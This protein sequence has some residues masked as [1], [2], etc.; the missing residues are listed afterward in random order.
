MLPDIIDKPIFLLFREVT[1][2][3]RAYAHTLFFSFVLISTGLVLL[4]F[5][6]PALLAMGLS[7]FIHITLDR[8]WA[9]P[10]TLFWPILGPMAAGERDVF[11]SNIFQNVLKPEVYIPEILGLAV[12]I[13]F[14][15]RLADT[16]SAFGFIKAGRLE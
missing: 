5:R 10:I 14:G 3:G 8:M 13:Y 2:S 9:N 11:F 7:S 16:K 6:K 15:V 12:L 4:R 1:L